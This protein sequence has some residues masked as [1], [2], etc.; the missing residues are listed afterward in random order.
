[1]CVAPHWNWGTE[2]EMRAS[3]MPCSL[4]GQDIHQEAV[5]PPWWFELCEI[6]GRGKLTGLG[7]GF[8]FTCTQHF[9]RSNFPSHSVPCVGRL[10]SLPRQIP[11]QPALSNTLL[12]CAF[13]K[14]FSGIQGI[15]PIS[16]L[17]SRTSGPDICHLL[18]L[19]VLWV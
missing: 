8:E 9:N 13:E 6:G 14:P 3:K 4:R 16:L 2:K 19:V 17:V 15:F 11:V 12:V 10:F 7:V 5:M 18:S 1:M